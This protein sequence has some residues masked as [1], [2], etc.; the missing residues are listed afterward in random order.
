MTTNFDPQSLNAPQHDAVQDYGPQN[1][2]PAVIST[3]WRDGLMVKDSYGVA[4]VATG[5]AANVDQVYEI[6]SQTK[7]MTSTMT[8]QLVAEGKIDLDAKLTDY[9]PAEAIAGIANADQVTIKQLLSNRTGIPDY[10]EIPGESGIPIMIE[11]ILTDPTR[12]I[13][14]DDFLD[15]VRDL[16]ADFEPGE[17]YGYSNTN[18]LFLGRVIEAVTG[19][20]FADELQ[21][22]IFDPAGMDS[23]SLNT[24]GVLGDLLHSYSTHPVDG[25]LIDV[26]SIPISFAGEG[27][28][29]STT[30]DMVRFLDALFVSKTLLPQDM[31]D[32]MTDFTEIASSPDGQH[33]F[34]FGLGLSHITYLGQSFYGFDGG[35]LGTNS[36]TY[37]H[38]ES[39]TIVSVVATHSGTSPEQLAFDVF[40][41]V[42]AD[43]NW[44]SFDAD[45]D[46]FDIA[47]TAAEI[48]LTEAIDVNGNAQTEFS[49]D[50]A[51]LT[52]D[53]SLS[54][55][56][57]GRF[58]F[59]DGSVLKIGDAGRDSFDI[60][61]DM[62]EASHADNQLLGLEGNDWLGGGHGND[63]LKG[64]AGNDRLNGRS[65][66][67]HI[68]GGTGSDRL[69]GGQG[70]DT[71]DG[72]NGRD[73]LRG[74]RGDDQVSGG[75]GRD[76]LFGGR[77]NDVLDG[78]AGEDHLFGG[79]GADQFVFN[80]QSGN[81]TIFDFETGVDKL[82][83]S[84]TGLSFDDLD[85][86]TDCS[87]AVTISYGDNN[88]LTTFEPVTEA[89]FIF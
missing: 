66:D 23:S 64:G 49:L 16:P 10:D 61:R 4:D 34:G 87:G 31:L 72:G 85:I 29:M 1:P 55:L 11:K 21:T 44:A 7:M 12:P 39:G 77:G 71:L 6:G 25:S 59:E 43:E 84:Q 15:I 2:S 80:L 81:D 20:S 79:E 51:S 26:T 41:A 68:E 62:A 67:D 32:E 83:F 82:D 60:L 48:D 30:A 89:D 65:G 38:V 13:G 47:G 56:D 33:A 70:N 42:F 45:A 86:S 27:G 46:S 5:Q 50:S 54:D 52:F 36:S 88:S 24:N 40:Q 63:V 3:V 78:G 57:G 9:L 18:F 69:S 74:G 14:P 73:I 19:N 53:G 22:R 76:L 8:L 58:V 28:V 17:K 37:V 75:A 35:T